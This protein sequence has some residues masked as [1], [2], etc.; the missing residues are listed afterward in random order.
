MEKI[1]N[2]VANWRKGLTWPKIILLIIAACVLAVAIILAIDPRKQF[3]KLRNNERRG[4]VVLILNAVYQYTVD[5]EG[6]LPAEL[7]EKSQAICRKGADCQGLVD[8]SAIVL[9]KKNSAYLT[10]MPVD[11]SSKQANSTGYEIKKVGERITVSAPL[12]EQNATIS[13][14]R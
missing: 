9:K 4:D 14:T 2:V 13:S 3:A 1:K 5:N 11:P 12:A 10:S 7:N 6:N 8:L